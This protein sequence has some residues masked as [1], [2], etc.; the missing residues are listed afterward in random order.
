MIVGVCRR[1]ARR[2]AE[3]GPLFALLHR[4]RLLLQPLSNL[5][6]MDEVR[7]PAS[8]NA[9]GSAL[10]AVWWLTVLALMVAILMR[11][12]PTTLYAT[13]RLSLQQLLT[14]LE[15]LVS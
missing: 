8:P 15:L 10:K 11:R 13:K 5:S 2:L 12:S 3:A 7:M 14:F 6:P 4:L 1:Q 9:G